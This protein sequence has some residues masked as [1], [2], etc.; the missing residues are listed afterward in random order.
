MT[1]FTTLITE[2]QL[3]IH[4]QTI[5]TP[6]LLT[7]L[8]QKEIESPRMTTGEIRTWARADTLL[9]DRVRA[10]RL[11]HPELRQAA[12][13]HEVRQAMLYHQMWRDQ[14]LWWIGC[15]LVSRFCREVWRRIKSFHFFSFR[16]F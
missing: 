5:T 3:V 8:W 15:H 14:P 10:K 16:R 13:L 4:A 2:F 6:D 12:R 7:L 1:D 9:M 11:S